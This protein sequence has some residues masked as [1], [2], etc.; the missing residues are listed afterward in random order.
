MDHP[1]SE[2]SEQVHPPVTGF[3]SVK[4]DILIRF[5]EEVFRTKPQASEG[6]ANLPPGGTCKEIQETDD[7][8]RN[9]SER[10]RMCDGQQKDPSGYSADPSAECESDSSSV[11]PTRMKSIAQERERSNTQETNSRYCPRLLQTQRLS[12]GERPL[13]SADTGENFTTD[14]NFVE[15]HIT[16]LGSEAHYCHDMSKTSPL[17]DNAPQDKLY[18]CSECGKRSNQ[19]SNIRKHKKIH[20]GEKRY[21]CTECGK[22]FNGQLDLRRHKRIH[23]GEKPF[24]CPQCGK[25]FNHQSNLKKHK[26]I[27]TGE[28]P[29]SCSECNKSFNDQSDLRRHKRIHTGEKPY[30]CP[31]CGKIFNQQANLKIHK[32]IHTGE[33]PYV[34]PECGKRFNQQSHL[35]MHKKIHVSSSP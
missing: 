32:R 13:D 34:C 12:E 9:N 31:E 15:H 27:H 1:E 30:T 33:K 25:R 2:M 28:K 6:R 7:G 29:Y 3:P 22:S 35:K 21:T 24:A 4:P 8:N 18:A 16:W 14:L 11:K 20:S 26:R 5:K 10:T 23:T 19:Q 17:K